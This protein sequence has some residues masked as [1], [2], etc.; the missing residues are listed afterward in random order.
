MTATPQSEYRPSAREL[1]VVT[2]AS[3][4]IGFELARQFADH[5]FDLVVNAEDGDLRGAAARLAAN[6]SQVVPVQA[7]LRTER[8]VQELLDA[9][10]ALGR[11]VAAAALNAGVGVGGAFVD[12]DLEAELDLIDLNIGSTLRLA[13]R[14]LRDMA[15]RDEGRILVTSSIAATMP[16]TFQAVYNASKSFLQSFVEALQNELKDTGVTVTSLMP[17]PTET[18]FFHR[19]GMDDTRVGRQDKDDPAQVAQQGFDALMSGRPRQVAGSAKT[20]ALEAGNKALPD[21]VKARMHR[22]MAEPGS[23]EQ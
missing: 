13:K 17:G 2:G 6:G 23:G 12:T 19:A 14:L 21:S 18:E 9:I 3:R 5:G 1:A 4:G 22:T 7:D 11:P 20:K 8:G 10:A 15:A 16:G